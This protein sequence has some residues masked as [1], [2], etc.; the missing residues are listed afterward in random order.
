MRPSWLSSV[1]FSSNSVGMRTPLSV[2]KSA[3]LSRWSLEST[4]STVSRPSALSARLC[5]TGSSARHGWHHDAQMLITAG[6][7][8]DRSE[9]SSSPVKQGNVRSG[10][11]VAPD[12]AE[13]GAA[14]GGTS[15]KGA[16]PAKGEETAGSS[17]LQATDAVT[18]SRTR[19]AAS[20]R[21]R[22]PSRPPRPPREGETRDAAEDREGTTGDAAEDREGTTGDAAEGREGTTGD[23]AE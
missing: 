22:V 23:A 21:E 4:P 3:P 20:S 12:P 15:V 7:R 9:I 8:S 11:S 16:Q 18:S 6:P 14:D 10:R 13:M 17:A 19:G 5:M 1:P 2:A